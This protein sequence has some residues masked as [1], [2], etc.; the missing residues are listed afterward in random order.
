MIDMKAYEQITCA[1]MLEVIKEVFDTSNTQDK[2]REDV[3]SVA[4]C[5]VP[6]QIHVYKNRPKDWRVT[7][8][9]PV[10]GNGWDEML[11]AVHAINA[12]LDMRYY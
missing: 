5:G 1:E 11:M 8:F 3:V 2:R 7:G 9:D 12:E 4:V 10:G 6:L